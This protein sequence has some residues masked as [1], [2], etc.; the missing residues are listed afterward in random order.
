[1]V[2]RRPCRGAALS[3]FASMSA[4]DSTIGLRCSILI[5]YQRIRI[6]RDLNNLG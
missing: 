2:K 4:I 1:L 3:F 5:N 6:D